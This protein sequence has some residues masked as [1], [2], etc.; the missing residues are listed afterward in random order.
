MVY[1]I[2]AYQSVTCDHGCSIEVYDENPTPCQ[3]VYQRAC[4]KLQVVPSRQVF[5]NLSLTEVILPRCGLG[6]KELKALAIALVHNN[7][8][9]TL[10]LHCNSFGSLGFAYL[11]EMLQ[12]NRSIIDLNVSECKLGRQGVQMLNGLQGNTSI[13]RLNLSD[14]GFME[15]DACYV[16]DFIQKNKNLRELNLSYN[17]LRELGGVF[18]GGAIA[19]NTALKSLDLSWNH[20]RLKGA[21][22][23]SHGLMTNRSL[24]RLLLSWNGF[25]LEGSIEMGRALAKNNTLIELDLTSNRINVPAF[26][27]IMQGL[28]KNKTLRILKIG[29]NPLSSDGATSVT[30]SLLDKN[31]SALAELDL[32]E[33]AVD[34]SFLE[35]VERVKKTRK[36]VVKYGVEIR[37]DDLTRI[38][39]PIVID[40]DDPT[41]VLFE[42]MRQ[43]NLRLI[44]LLHSLDKDNSETL[45]REELRKGLLSVQIPL[46]TRSMDL[47]M[48]RLDLNK[49]GHIDFEELTVGLRDYIRRTTKW[50]QQRGLT[51]EP[52]I[53]RLENLRERIR[54][55]RDASRATRIASTE[56]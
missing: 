56:L 28:M 49:D 21:A 46:S 14:N 30:R 41:T 43:K 27:K 20:L 10:D 5:Q 16:G 12:E 13:V 24:T 54:L 52:I 34:S 42:Y 31:N 39:R 8:V 53:G 9:H 50:R 35:L 32:S 7:S 37:T 29:T 38:D 17:S 51:A 25:A 55:R 40:M 45:S 18:V 47:M 44:D 22:A 36:I 3:T 33:V 26:R 11:V 23:I 4:E 6:V 15:S 2:S 1:F 19:V 48:N